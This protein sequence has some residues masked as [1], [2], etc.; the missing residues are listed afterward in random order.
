[1]KS[2]ALEWWEKKSETDAAAGP[3]AQVLTI[4]DK[5][6]FNSLAFPLARVQR[7]HVNWP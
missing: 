6:S 4:Y 5:W 7:P 3:S 2:V 1:M